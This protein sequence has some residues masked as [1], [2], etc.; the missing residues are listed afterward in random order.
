MSNRVEHQK[1]NQVAAELPPG[2]VFGVQLGLRQTHALIKTKTIRTRK[3]PP[4]ILIFS[5][6]L[7]L[8]SNIAGGTFPLLIVF[9]LNQCLYLPKAKLNTKNSTKWRRKGSF[10]WVSGL[11]IDLVSKKWSGYQGET[12][13]R[14]TIEPTMTGIYFREI[15]SNRSLS[16]QYY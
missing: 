16:P 13:L 10:G 2:W 1:L 12:C 6:N 15:S 4:A 7:L 11:P 3:V 14:R 5:S 8:N 9:V